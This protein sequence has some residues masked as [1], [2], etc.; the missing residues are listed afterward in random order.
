MLRA[1]TSALRLQWRAAPG[2]SLLAAGLVGVAGLAGP[3]GGWFLKSLLDGLGN[4]T[5]PAAAQLVLLAVGAAGAAGV[6]S[7]A[8]YVSGYLSQRA[9]L[10]LGVAVERALFE[11]V[12]GLVGLQELETPALHGKLQ[13]AEQAAREA[14][15]QLSELALS[16]L[17]TLVAVGSALGMVWWVAPPMVWVLL[18]AGALG[19]AA[20]I[21]RSRLDAQ[22]AQTLVRTYRWRDYY[23]SLLLDVRGAREARLLGLGP[24]LVERMVQAL[25]RAGERETAL[26]GTHAARQGGLALL[27]AAVI[28][29]GLAAVVLGVSR[30]RY[31]LGDVALVLAAAT[32]LQGALSSLAFELGTATRSALLFRS[33]LEV[34][35]LP[36]S[37]SGGSPAPPLQRAVELR[38]VW[39]RYSPDGPWVLRGVNLTLRRGQTLGLVGLN[40]S[41]KSTLVKLLCRFFEPER[42]TILWDAVD[43]RKLEVGSLRR[44]LTA[45]F[46][47]FMTYDATAAENVAFGD[48]EAL[49]D[50][51]RIHTAAARAEIHDKLRGLAGGYDTLLSRRLESEEP[52]A[53]EGASL[54]GGEWQRLALAR[55]LFRREADVLI[56]DEPT[57]GLDAGAEFRLTRAV[58]RHCAASTRLLISHRLSAL[59]EADAIV[60]LAGGRVVE[61]GDHES[62]MAL[63]GRYAELF[64]LQARGYQD[65]R[66]AAGPPS[67]A[68]GGR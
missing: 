43:V 17:R 35:S 20:S 47:D 32:G 34:L 61:E 5:A 67:A 9:Q 21:Q 12:N 10:G 65:A 31:Q 38:D 7:A 59:R 18:L 4:P 42:G 51:E 11:K 63:G 60:V 45:T 15:Q 14:P 22:L 50:L 56:L 24:L 6:G 53:A 1:L 40:G 41:G 37:G 33:Y 25:K 28:A 46:Q 58:L 27:S 57:S 13:L 16:L 36:A 62:L 68:R 19:V 26:A 29:A 55:S 30:G 48:V 54:S 49:M 39:F 23:R 66:L 8:I 64:A 52:G 44:R 3:A 2:L